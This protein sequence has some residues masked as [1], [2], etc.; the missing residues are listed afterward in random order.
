MPDAGHSPQLETPDHVIHA[1][2]DSADTDFS[3]FAR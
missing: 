1:I 3:A 2:W